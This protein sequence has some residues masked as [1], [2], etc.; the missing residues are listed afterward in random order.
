MGLLYFLDPQLEEREQYNPIIFEHQMALPRHKLQIV[1]HDQPQLLQEALPLSHPLIQDLV[2][3]DAHAEIKA[4]PGG[5]I[6]CQCLGQSQ[7]IILLLLSS[8]FI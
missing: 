2:Q 3:G 5:D 6:Q 4:I 7:L 1:P 8:Y